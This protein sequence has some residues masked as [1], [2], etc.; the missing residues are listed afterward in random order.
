MIA[1]FFP[2][3]Y[4]ARLKERF[5]NTE[6]VDGAKVPCFIDSKSRGADFP[7][8]YFAGTDMGFQE[9][10]SLIS[11]KINTELFYLTGK[12]GEAWIKAYIKEDDDG[13]KIKMLKKLHFDALYNA[14]TIP[15]VFCPYVSVVRRPWKMDFPRYT[16]DNNFWQLSHE[17]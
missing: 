13:K 17:N 16:Y 11:Y 14:A 15:I 5:P 9:D 12:D 4:I 1:W 8:F 7:H 2:K 10:I 6:F 3:R